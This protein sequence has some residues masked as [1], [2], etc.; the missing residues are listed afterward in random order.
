[1]NMKRTIIFGDIH[2][3]FDEWNDLMEKVSVTSEDVL[4]TVGDMICRGPASQ[5]VLD[6][7]IRLPSLI[8]VLGNHE[9]RFLTSWKNGCIPKSRSYDIETVREM[10]DHFESYMNFLSTKHFYANLPDV[11]VV[12]AGL[13]PGLSLEH[14]SMEDLTQIR[15]VGHYQRPWYEF[16]TD[17]KPVVFGHWVRR[18]PLIR[19]NAI[20]LDTGCVYGGSLSAY[21]FPDQRVVSVPAKKVYRVRSGPWA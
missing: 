21:L 20:G 7:A 6:L 15:E 11:L 9:L 17:T 2:G 5:K 16:Y 3:C 10:G 13:K 1:M 14:Q 18:K 8:Y 12:H 4:V 19:Q